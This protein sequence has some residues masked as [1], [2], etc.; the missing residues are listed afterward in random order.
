MYC[1]FINEDR[2]MKLLLEG[3]GEKMENDGEGK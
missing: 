2:R 1:V 3:G